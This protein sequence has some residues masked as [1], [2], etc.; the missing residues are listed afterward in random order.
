MFWAERFLVLVVVS[1]LE[2]LLRWTDFL[3]LPFYGLLF[4]PLRRSL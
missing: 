1:L 2:S 4:D 3:D